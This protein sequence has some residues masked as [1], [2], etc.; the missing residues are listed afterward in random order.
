MYIYMRILNYLV[1]N[2]KLITVKLG[3]ITISIVPTYNLQA[4]YADGTYY[5]YAHFT[6]TL[7]Q[8]LPS[9]YTAI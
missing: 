9:L 5:I 8:Q 7:I 4:I 3:I 2:F 6:F 1:I